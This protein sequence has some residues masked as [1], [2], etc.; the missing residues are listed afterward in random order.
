MML[1][2]DLSGYSERK[3]GNGFPDIII[4]SKPMVHIEIT[5]SDEAKNR[6][7]DKPAEMSLTKTM[8][9]K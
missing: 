2:K 4:G 7:P 3:G 6:D 5:T 8:D 1:K 9:R